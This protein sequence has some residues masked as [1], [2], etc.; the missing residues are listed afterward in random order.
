MVERESLPKQVRERW[1]NW[2]NQVPVFGFNSRK[3]DLDLVKE[4]FVKILSDMNDVTVAKKDN[5]YMFLMTPRFKFL[6]VKKYLTPD[7]SYVGWCKANG[8]VMEK[9]VFSYE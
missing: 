7:L 6:D 8:C 5:S 4:Y 1:I 3:Y 9:L 2:V